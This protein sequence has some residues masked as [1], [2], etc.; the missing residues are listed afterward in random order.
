MKSVRIQPTKQGEAV[1][2]DIVCDCGNNGLVNPATG[3]WSFKHEV[4]LAS[5][6]D[7]NLLCNHCGATYV[8]HPQKTHVHVNEIL[9]EVEFE[10][11]DG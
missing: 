7:V 8:L 5:R 11:H 3:T 4:A 1:L 6:E 2:I 9:K 10:L